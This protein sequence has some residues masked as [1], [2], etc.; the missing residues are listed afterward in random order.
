MESEVRGSRRQDEE[1]YETVSRGDGSWIVDTVE[2][3]QEWIC[4]WTVR[5]NAFVDFSAILGK[6]RPESLRGAGA[7][8]LEGLIDRI[9]PGT[10]SVTCGARRSKLGKASLQASLWVKRRMKSKVSTFAV[11]TI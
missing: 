11:S 1:D 8:A 4:S 9:Q 3:R 5:H 7:G 2:G 6:K 10:G